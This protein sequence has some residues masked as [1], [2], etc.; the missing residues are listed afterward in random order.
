MEMTECSCN[1]YIDIRLYVCS[2]DSPSSHSSLSF[3][4][5]IPLTHLSLIHPSHS[6]QSSLS[7]ISIVEKLETAARLAENVATKSPKP[8]EKLVCTCTH[9]RVHP[10]LSLLLCFVS[11]SRDH[12]SID[13]FC[14]LYTHTHTHNRQTDRQTDTHT[15]THTHTRIYIYLYTY[16]H[17]CVGRANSEWP[18][19]CCVWTLQRGYCSFYG[20]ALPIPLQNRKANN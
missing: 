4:P 16:I 15:H 8:N 10:R 3:I 7:S 12:R 17:A 20:I 11:A 13:S 2:L 14:G 19:G 1:V 6:P 9:A 18:R 5:L